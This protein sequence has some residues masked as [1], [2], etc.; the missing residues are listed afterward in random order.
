[1][2]LHIELIRYKFKC[3]MLT[4]LLVETHQKNYLRIQELRKTSAALDAQIRGTLSTLATTRKD[5]LTTQTTSYST[6]P[7]YPIGYEELLRYARRISKTTMP[8]ASA[9]NAF[10]AASNSPPGGQTPMPEI[11]P[12]TGMTPSAVTPSQTQTQSPAM[13]MD[14]SFQDQQT[15]QQTTTSMANTLPEAMTQFLNP[16]SGQVFFPWPLEDKIRGGALASNQ[17]LT[18]RGIDPKGYDPAEEEERKRREEL[19][20]KEKEDKEREEREERERKAKEERERA[21]REREREQEEWRKQSAAAGIQTGAGP[22]GPSRSNTEVGEK[23]QFQFT[24]LDDL[25]DDDDDEN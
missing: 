15:T 6:G 16:L 13:A 11:Q 14:I 2:V 21:R 5:V 1:M 9:I 19:E 17:V 10:P 22:S 3:G 7:S 8:S 4:L 20:R 23:K 18:E 24:S 25:E 12:Q